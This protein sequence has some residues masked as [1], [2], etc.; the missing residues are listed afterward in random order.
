MTKKITAVL[1]S[2]IMAISMCAVVN[3]AE[4]SGASEENTSAA[5]DENTSAASDENTSAAS[6]EKSDGDDD[7]LI[8]IGTIEADKET[9]RPEMTFGY[10]LYDFT[11][12][13]LA[14]VRDMTK[15]E[16]EEEIVNE[17]EVLKKIT[18][19]NDTP[20]F[21]ALEE[22]LKAEHKGITIIPISIDATETFEFPLVIEMDFSSTGI[23]DGTYYLYY[24]NPTTGKYEKQCE[25]DVKNGTAYFTLKHCSK[26]FLS[27]VDLPDAVIPKDSDKGIVATKVPAT[28]NPKTGAGSALL[29]TFAIIG[30]AGAAVIVKTK[31]TR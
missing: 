11:D 12:E 30:I 19:R 27:S 24:M 7:F 16:L 6:D 18:L 14:K 2:C 8:Q 31:K 22:K 23:K 25:I 26:Y 1:L 17:A 4:T 20:E 21:K 3:A 29:A 15:E 5:S 10:N 13:Q 9:G 28:T